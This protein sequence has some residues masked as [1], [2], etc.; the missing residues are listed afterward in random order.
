MPTL[1]KRIN[2]TVT[3]ELEKGISEAALRDNVPQATKAAELL[4]LALEFEEDVV[5]DTLAARRDTPKA[6]YVRHEKVWK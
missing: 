2:I 4:R 3:S 5:W 1:K 6:K